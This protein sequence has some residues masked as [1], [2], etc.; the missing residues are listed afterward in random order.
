MPSLLPSPD[1]FHSWEDWGRALLR[2]L[3]EKEPV[4]GAVDLPPYGVNNLPKANQPGQ[5]IYV[6]DDVGGAV[7]AFSD[8]SEWRRVTD[9]AIV[10]LT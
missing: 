9:R 3:E 4:L 2:V 5:L 6:T 10:S 8:G 1:M 7:P